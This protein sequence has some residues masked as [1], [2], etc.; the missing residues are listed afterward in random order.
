M[1]KSKVHGHRAAETMADKPGLL[2]AKRVQQPEEILGHG[3]RVIARRGHFTQAVATQVVRSD[4]VLLDQ[5]RENLRI[6]EGQ[7]G[8]DPMQENDIRAGPLL[9]IMDLNSVRK[10]FR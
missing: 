3:V 7:G 8:S 5:L 1:E 6:P 10:Y 2:D 9:L 4:P